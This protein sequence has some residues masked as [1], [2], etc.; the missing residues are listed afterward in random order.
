MTAA[1]L[2]NPVHEVQ[3]PVCDNCG[4]PATVKGYHIDAGSV[5]ACAGCAHTQGR[6]R[7][8]TQI[9]PL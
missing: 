6:D 1:P 9:R 4:D 7:E 5:Y 3:I 8:L 2:V